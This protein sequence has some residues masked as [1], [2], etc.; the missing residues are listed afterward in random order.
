MKILTVVEA[1]MRK[2][3]SKY[4]SKYAKLYGFRIKHWI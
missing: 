3:W 1:R 4:W 2:Y